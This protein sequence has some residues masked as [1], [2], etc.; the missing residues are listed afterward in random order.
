MRK[1]YST[2]ISGGRDQSLNRAS[3]MSFCRNKPLT[4]L[5]TARAKTDER[6]APKLASIVVSQEEQLTWYVNTWGFAS[7][8][9]K[10]TF[11]KRTSAAMI[12]KHL[13]LWVQT[14]LCA[15]TCLQPDR[16]TVWISWRKEGRELLRNFVIVCHVSVTTAQTN[17]IDWRMLRHSAISHVLLTVAGTCSAS[18]ESADSSHAMLQISALVLIF[19]ISHG[20]SLSEG[21]CSFFESKRFLFEF[22]FFEVY[23]LEGS[24]WYCRVNI[25]TT[26]DFVKSSINF[27]FV[28]LTCAYLYVSSL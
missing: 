21:F 7:K 23:L 11:A 9:Y 25:Y 4:T 5:R 16:Q 8:M 19:A 2:T 1:A 13:R 17:Q 26:S 22:Y 24:F 20:W 14:S 6:E 15:A 27:I 10:I 12:A 3:K 28:F 18:T